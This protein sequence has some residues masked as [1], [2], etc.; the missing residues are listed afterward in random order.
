MSRVNVYVA[1]G[2]IQSITTDPLVSVMV[3]VAEEENSDEWESVYDGGEVYPGD[4]EEF[5]DRV[6]KGDMSR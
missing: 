5:R 2:V 1:G 6:A 4:V 3:F